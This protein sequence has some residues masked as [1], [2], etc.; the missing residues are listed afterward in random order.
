[1]VSVS[2]TKR[3]PSNCSPITSKNSIKSKQNAI[4][5]DLGPF[6]HHSYK[7]LEQAQGVLLLGVEN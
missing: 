6:Q 1:M 7:A 2:R 5:W 4:L 3:F